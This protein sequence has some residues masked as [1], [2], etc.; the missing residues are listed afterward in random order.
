MKTGEVMG[1]ICRNLRGRFRR[2]GQERDKMATGRVQGKASGSQIMGGI[3]EE[4]GKDAAF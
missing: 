1:N 2:T 3:T 4:L